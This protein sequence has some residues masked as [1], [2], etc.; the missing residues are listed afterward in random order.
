L[1]SDSEPGSSL[2]TLVKKLEYSFFFPQERMN[3]SWL[4]VAVLLSCHAMAFGFTSSA[5]SLPKCGPYRLGSVENIPI[6][7]RAAIGPTQWTCSVRGSN[8]SSSNKQGKSL[9]GLG[10]RKKAAALLLASIPLFGT[11]RMVVSRHTSQCIPNIC[12]TTMFSHTKSPI[13]SSIRDPVSSYVFKPKKK[14]QASFLR[15]EVQQHDPWDTCTHEHLR[16][17]ASD[18]LIRTRQ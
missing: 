17:N 10:L 3:S 15:A 11:P 7:F 14:K 16:C 8:D 2:S 9:T 13:P 18:V 6:G 1:N 5:T 4:C 12:G